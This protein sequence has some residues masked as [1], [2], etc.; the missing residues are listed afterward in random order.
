MT[1]RRSEKTRGPSL[2]TV[3]VAV[4]A[5]ILTFLLLVPFSG[6]DTQPPVCRAIF[7]YEVPCA[8]WT[9][10]L[11]AAAAAGIVGVAFWML[12]DRRRDEVDERGTAEPVDRPD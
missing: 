5:G 10:P 8:E 1:N 3:V 7:F 12:L 9:A 11:V 4:L 2:G 6:V